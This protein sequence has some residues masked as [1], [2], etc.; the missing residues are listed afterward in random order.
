M[1]TGVLVSGTGTNLGA[2]LEAEAAG[3][4]APAVIACVISNRPGVP[5]LERARLYEKPAYV[6]EHRGFRNRGTF[7]RAMLATLREHG[8][9]FVVL[10]GFMRLLTQVFLGA[11]P[12]RVINI[13]PSLLPAFPGMRP[14]QQALESGCRITGCSVHYV[15]AGVDTG[16]VIAQ[17]QVPVKVDDDEASLTRRI[18]V[19][20]HILLPEVVQQIASMRERP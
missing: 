17:R 14:V 2:L 13:H 11:L 8:V 1:R 19:Q 7:E 4:L 20:E 12:Q 9:E 15:D 5:A 10:A 16:P 3:S 6:L 18:Q